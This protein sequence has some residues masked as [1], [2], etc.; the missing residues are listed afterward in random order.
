MKKIICVLSAVLAVLLIFAGGKKRNSGRSRTRRRQG[1]RRSDGCYDGLGKCSE[2][3]EPF[4]KRPL[5]D[6][7]G[8]KRDVIFERVTASGALFDSARSLPVYHAD[9]RR[10]QLLFEERQG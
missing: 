8:G 2:Y 7:G 1:H 6:N 3:A 4:R 9:K 10:S 5:S